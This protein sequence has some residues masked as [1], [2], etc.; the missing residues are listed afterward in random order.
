MRVENRRLVRRL[1][2]LGYSVNVGVEFS[3][4]LCQWYIFYLFDVCL[5]P[6]LAERVPVDQ[7]LSL[8]STMSLHWNLDFND[9]IISAQTLLEVSPRARASSSGEAEVRARVAA[10]AV[11]HP[12][13]P[14]RLVE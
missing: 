12:C 13:G 11:P 6:E 1:N 4:Q 3:S 10:R 8:L 2:R 5:S 7:P 9:K 14:I